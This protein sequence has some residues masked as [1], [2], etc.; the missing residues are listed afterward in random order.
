MELKVTPI[1][2]TPVKVRHLWTIIMRYVP[3]DL[4]VS[5]VVVAVVATDTNN[6]PA[7]AEPVPD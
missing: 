4:N 5:V 7:S 2:V 1:G 6:G 3:G